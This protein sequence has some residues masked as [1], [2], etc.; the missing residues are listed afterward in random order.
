MK[1]VLCKKRIAAFSVAFIITAGLLAAPPTA[2]AT[3]DYTLIDNGLQR[4]PIAKPY[5]HVM[6]ISVVRA[7]ENGRDTLNNAT[8]MF[9]NKAGHLFVA[10]TG[11][12]RIVKFAKDGGL[13]GVFTGPIERPLSA[14]QG[15]WADENG[16]MYIADTGNRRILHLDYEGNFVEEFG[17]PEGIYEDNFI[18]DP[19]KVAV[20]ESGYIYALKGTRLMKID[21]DN[22]FQGYMGQAKTRFNLIEFLRRMVYTES[23]MIQF[24]RAEMPAECTNF[25][26]DGDD[27]VWTTTLD[28]RY[29]ELKKLNAI[30]E[31]IYYEYNPAKPWQRF[32]ELLFGA[33]RALGKLYGERFF[34]LGNGEYMYYPDFRGV[35]VDDNQI[36]Y[37]LC[38]AENR[39]Y[40]YDREG[41]IICSFG[42]DWMRPDIRDGEFYGPSGIVVD[43]DG[44]VY[45]L[46]RILNNIQIFSP[47]E[48]VKT[49]HGALTEYY[50]GDYEAARS[51]WE[52]VLK[53]NGSY[54]LA[55]QGI[56]TA[57][58]KQE[59]YYESMAEYRLAGDYAGYSRA[60]SKYRHEQF[61]DNFALVVF[62]VAAAAALAVFLV[63][64]MKKMA[65]K[66]LALLYEGTEKSLGPV[67]MLRASFAVLFHP[68]ELFGL[69]KR[70]RTRLKY[71]PSIVLFALMAAVRV[72]QI[73]GTHF[74]IRMVDPRIAVLFSQLGQ[75]LAPVLSL[76]VMHFAVT[77]VVG[78][79]AKLGEIFVATAYSTVPYTMFTFLLVLVSPL[80]GH[81]ERGLMWLLI[82]IAA[83][84]MYILFIRTLS[85]L[86]DYT[87]GKTVIVAV[88]VLAGVVLAWVTILLVLSL[89]N[90]L[91]DFF[92]GIIREI[93]FSVWR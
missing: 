53:I 40:Q 3:N 56:A 9:M 38:N 74:G 1:N 52:T 8:D 31:S 77:S 51:S 32:Q 17:R 5:E 68:G 23:Q 12:N 57:L 55:H 60:Y 49:V 33:L 93:R 10:D 4:L 92:T 15:V 58:Y 45:I 7:L 75:L 54:P 80:M 72:Y 35:A 82:Y 50:S 18:F 83:G 70:H 34:Y 46:D 19:T 25:F 48:F 20:T 85:L 13:L 37:A 78:G 71:W 36:V 87:P 63:M 14:P 76:V 59:R 62:A 67:N 28:K 47:T 29:G 81:D 39:I 42:S 22:V 91:F 86:N 16:N 79:E 64:M 69:V 24:G 84:W 27:M 88:L 90:Q 65:D 44:R 30:G 41:R 26:L 73:Y 11:N 61:R 43:G 2:L 66:S 21:A 89:T 6:T